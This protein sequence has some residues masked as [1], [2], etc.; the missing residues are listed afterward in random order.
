MSK[1][2]SKIA[3]GLI[4]VL[5]F[6]ACSADSKPAPGTSGNA[7]PSASSS[8]SSAASEAASTG[9][10]VISVL[11]AEP[12]PNTFT[13]DTGGLETSTSGAAMITFT[14]SGT[15]A[16]ELRLVKI[17]DGNFAAYRAAVVVNSDGSS[18]AALVDEV[19]KSPSIEPGASSTFGAELS[20]G[21]YAWVCLLTA[22]GGKTFAQ[23][24]MI[25][26]LTVSPA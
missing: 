19:A 5:A 2:P 22:P 25:R 16:H 7:V 12:A 1:L 26:E 3:F 14:N 23:L 21:T 20:A 18:A 8:S 17:K 4:A 11:A 6:A 10:T 24:G 13:F 15:M 9:P